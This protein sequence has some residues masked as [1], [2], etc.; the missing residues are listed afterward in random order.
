M[1]FTNHV[2]LVGEARVCRDLHPR[3]GAI[4]RTGKGAMQT[5]DAEHALRRQAD[6]LH[7]AGV[8][9]SGG[10]AGLKSNVLDASMKAK[11]QASDLILAR[12]SVAKK[13]TAQKLRN[14]VERANW[15]LRSAQLLCQ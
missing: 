11:R 13:M 7:H 4:V 3:N 14:Y 1:K 10:Q 8:Q 6:V 9:R 12:A 15:R 2:G 5:L